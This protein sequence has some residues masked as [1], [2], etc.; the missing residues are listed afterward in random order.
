VKEQLK[1]AKTINTLEHWCAAPMLHH[2][3]LCKQQSPAYIYPSLLQQFLP[4]TESLQKLAAME[5]M[6]LTSARTNSNG[7]Q[8]T[9]AHCGFCSQTEN[10]IVHLANNSKEKK[11]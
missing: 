5:Q 10:G 7:S 3:L 6:L 1:T 9:S 4:T 11:T 2:H 8:F